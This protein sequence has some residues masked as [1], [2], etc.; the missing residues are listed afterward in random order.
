MRETPLVFAS[1]RFHPV[2]L[3][4]VLLVDADGVDELDAADERDDAV[5]F[6]AA[7]WT[8]V[9]PLATVARGESGLN[10]AHPLSVEI[11]S[12]APITRKLR[13]RDVPG[14]GDAPDAGVVLPCV[15]RMFVSSLALGPKGS[16]AFGRCGRSAFPP[17]AARNVP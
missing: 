15:M 5:G 8:V 9:S 7:V 10:S 3:V 2:V 1:M 4:E 13:F 12:A 6:G 16:A 11:A 14:R 17:S